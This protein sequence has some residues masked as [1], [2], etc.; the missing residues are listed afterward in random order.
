VQGEL[1]HDAVQSQDWTVP[2]TGMGQVTKRAE[3][4]PSTGD[5]HPVLMSQAKEGGRILELA[6][7]RAEVA[8]LLYSIAR[9]FYGGVVSARC[10]PEDL[11]QEADI[12]LVNLSDTVDADNNPAKYTAESYRHNL[13]RMW[14]KALRDRDTIESLQQSHDFL[15]P[16]PFDNPVEQA[17]LA[18]ERLREFVVSLEEREMLVL[19]NILQPSDEVIAEL[20][21]RHRRIAY[22]KRQGKRVR[23][24]PGLRA[25]DIAA[26][27]GLPLGVV[28]KAITRIR[29]SLSEESS[30]P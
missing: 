6:T 11:R 25:W 10:E 20:Q 23:L 24:K 14:K 26:G 9:Q 5:G 22:L 18:R 27:T 16:D 3:G 30:N 7:L 12:L 1:S 29:G 28:R 15:P 2:K 21:A 19:A 17:V 13:R 4:S 8:P